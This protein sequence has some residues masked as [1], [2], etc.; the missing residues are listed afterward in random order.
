MDQDAIAPSSI[1]RP[2]D[3]TTADDIGSINPPRAA[4]PQVRI[5]PVVPGDADGLRALHTAASNQ[6]LYLRFFGYSRT[7]VEEYLTVLSRPASRTHQALTAQI[8]SRLVGVAAFERLTGDTAEVALLVADD[9]H[10]RGIGTLLMEHLAQ[11]A[12]NN[13]IHRFQADVL[14]ENDLA[15]R[16]VRDLGWPTQMRFHDGIGRVVADL[17]PDAATPPVGPHS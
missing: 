6:S 11:A 14:G 15:L 17:A 13:G 5:R 8:G 10:E 3:W 7:A 4:I 9:Y 12:R 1:P 16:M 2:A